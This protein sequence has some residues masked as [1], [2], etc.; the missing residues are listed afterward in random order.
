M[1]KLV[2]STGNADK[3][4][5]A[6]QV[7]ESLGLEVIQNNLDIVEIQHEDPKI[8]ALDK[9][10]KAF[11]IVKSPVVISDDSWSFEGLNGFPGA[12]MHS[13]NE[14]FTSQDFLNLT[15][16]LK[17]RKIIFTQYIV[18]KD[19]KRHQVFS[20]ISTG[21]LLKEIR[22]TSRHPSLNVTAMD[23]DGGLSIAEVV[24]QRINHHEHEAAIVWQD[25][26][27]WFKENG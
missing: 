5:T 22:G 26:L 25:C 6:R 2:I 27:S 21:T 12:F 10:Q 18:Y 17:N 13:M 3:F 20:R 24:E 1:K 14:W 7:A 19:A 16:P 15:L 9:A 8:I 23:S 11:D 4:F